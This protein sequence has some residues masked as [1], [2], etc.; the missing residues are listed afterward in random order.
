M[1]RYK[2]QTFIRV[3]L[4]ARATG[5]GSPSSSCPDGVMS[6]SSVVSASGRRRVRKSVE[7]WRYVLEMCEDCF[8]DLD[9]DREE[10]EEVRILC[11]RWPVIDEAVG[12]G[13]PKG[14]LGFMTAVN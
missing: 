13:A 2:L 10:M 4:E 5:A 12:L 9:D 14:L 8:V 6:G 3:V 1:V 7:A 11:D